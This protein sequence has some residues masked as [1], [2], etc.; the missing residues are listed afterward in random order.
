MHGIKGSVFWC[1]NLR[2]VMIGN[3][4]E[5]ADK[6]QMKKGPVGNDRCVEFQKEHCK[7]VRS[8]LISPR[9]CFQF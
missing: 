8:N 9:D 7:G 2:T 3:H 4:S 1:Y 5:E 6:S